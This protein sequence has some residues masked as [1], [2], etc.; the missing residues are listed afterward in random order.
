VGEIQR[1]RLA[2]QLGNKLWGIIY[3]LDEPTI[4]L[5]TKE[6]VNTIKAIKGLKEMGNTIIVVEHNEAFIKESDYIV[7]IGPGAGD[8]WWNLV[9]QW[10]IEEFMQQDTLTAQY[11]TG[12][13]QIEATFDHKP[14][15]H[16]IKVRWARKYNLQNVTV[17]IPLGGFTVIT[18][19]SGAGKTTLLHHTLFAFLQDKQ[20]FVQSFI[21]LRML[22]QGMSR[23]E[24]I[25]S[26][27]MKRELYQQM[28]QE[29]V[30]AF[31]EHLAVDD[32]KGFDKVDNVLYVDQASIGKTPRSCPAT[33]VGVFDDIRTLYAW[34]TDAKMLGFNSGH[35]S[36]NSKKGACPE[37]NGYGYKRIELQFLPDTY[38]PC[39]LCKGARY[40]PE[41]LSIKRHGKSIS[42]VLDMYVFDAMDLFHDMSH[43]ARPL[44]LMCDIGLWYLKMGQPAQMLSGGESQ[45]IK[46]VK[47]LLKSYKG[48]TMYFLDEPTVGLHP[49]DI[50]KLLLVMKKFLDQGDTIVMIEHEK[51]LLRFA[52]KVITLEEGRLV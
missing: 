30:I 35:F 22:K 31:Y 17:D 25:A 5:D 9:F 42:E 27:V 32:I 8:F 39:S 37:C 20:Q 1:L 16:A 23:Q 11:I 2:K 52:D 13:R 45:R 24:I 48:H 38:V 12:K 33:F 41:I 3:V 14:S 29:A 49:H 7:E 18:W 19:W 44:Q 4:G 46:L 28:E 51:N 34:A 40:K 10:P 21:R 26:P 36:F 6:I 47:H 50:E 43:I 15:T